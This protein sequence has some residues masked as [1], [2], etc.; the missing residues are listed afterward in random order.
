LCAAVSTPRAIPLKIAIPRAARSRDNISAIPAPYGDGCR[1]PTTPIPGSDSNST[2][3][4]PTA[5]TVDRRS[6]AAAPDTPH[7]PA[8][9]QTR[10]PPE[11]ASSPLPPLPA[12]YPRNRTV[13]PPT[14]CPHPPAPSTKP[15]T[16]SPP[17]PSAAPPLHTASAPYPASTPLPSIPAVSSRSLPS[18]SKSNSSNHS[19]IVR[20]RPIADAA[21]HR[22]VHPRRSLP[23]V[24]YPWP[25]LPRWIVPNMHPVT[26]R[27]FH[28]PLSRLILPK[29]IHL[30]LHPEPSV[31]Q[32]HLIPGPRIEPGAV[33][34]PLST[35]LESRRLSS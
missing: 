4:S 14:A 24:Q 17:I 26:A 15:Q 31:P 30:L 3:P 34:Q 28:H 32:T 13:P 8:S 33:P 16:A 35:A 5:P 6:P 29:S 11:P 19:R 7:P 9:A 20:F 2:P 25:D 1:V 18:L 22:S 21:L 10:P 23:G 27:K 12:L